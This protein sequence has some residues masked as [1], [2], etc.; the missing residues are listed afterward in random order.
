MIDVRTSTSIRVGR[1]IITHY[2]LFA[3]EPSD[4]R[5]SWSIELQPNSK[6][7]ISEVRISM[8]DFSEKPVTDSSSGRKPQPSEHTQRRLRSQ[9]DTFTLLI[10]LFTLLIGARWIIQVA[11]PLYLPAIQRHVEPWR[12]VLELEKLGVSE[13]K[14]P[15]VLT[16]TVEELQE[17]LTKGDV[18]SVQ[19]VKEYLVSPR[20][21][22][23]RYLDVDDAP[24]VR[25]VVCRRC[26]KNTA[27]RKTDDKELMQ[28]SP[29]FILNTLLSFPFIRLNTCRTGIVATNPNI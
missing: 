6:R 8:A 7:R 26:E 5:S 21:R 18:T 12:V 2:P 23:R 20:L 11:Y 4:S 10:G 16:A 24:K 29:S 9:V 1:W 17:A 3:T 28:T 15:D 14:G 19:L 22:S 13:W 25:Q 27:Y